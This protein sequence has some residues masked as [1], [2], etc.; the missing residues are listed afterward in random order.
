MR[1]VLR[2]G[3]DYPLLDYARAVVLHHN[4]RADI[5]VLGITNSAGRYNVQVELTIVDG[6]TAYS[7]N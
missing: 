5:C 7:R 2:A 3:K 4:K 1:T 6:D